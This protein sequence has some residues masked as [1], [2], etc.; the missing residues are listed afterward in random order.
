MIGSGSRQFTML[1]PTMLIGYGIN[2]YLFFFP[3]RLVTGGLLHLGRMSKGP[4]PFGN[5]GKRAK[6]KHLLLKSLYR[7]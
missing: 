3:D 7:P 2:A 4:V 5:I 1:P 6:G